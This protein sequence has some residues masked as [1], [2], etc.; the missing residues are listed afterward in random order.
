MGRVS[1]HEN[2]ME[3]IPELYSRKSASTDRRGVCVC[4]WEGFEINVTVVL[5]DREA[6][7]ANFFWPRLNGPCSGC[8]FSSICQCPTCA[9]RLQ[10]P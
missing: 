3:M 5:I 1:R 10:L 2:E 4:G 7:L 6:K 9:D 8:W